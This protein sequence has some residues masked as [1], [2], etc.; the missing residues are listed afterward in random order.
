M[1]GSG[2]ASLWFVELRA[3]HHYN[4]ISEK[5]ASFF[6]SLPKVEV[7]ELYASGVLRHW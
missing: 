3:W 5:L 4:C 2:T 1:Y 7:L 6:L